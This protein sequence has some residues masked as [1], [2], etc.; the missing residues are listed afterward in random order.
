MTIAIEAQQVRPQAEKRVTSAYRLASYGAG[1]ESCDLL[2][3][4]TV[5]PDQR[6][7]KSVGR[8]DDVSS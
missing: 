3:W 8:E 6:L 2:P 1:G 4:T 5:E 7:M